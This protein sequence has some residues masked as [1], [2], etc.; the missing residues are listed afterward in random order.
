MTTY[1]LTSAFLPRD[2]YH[3]RQWPSPR[4]LPTLEQPR[5]RNS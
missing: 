1:T 2:V 3:R 4:Q 5:I